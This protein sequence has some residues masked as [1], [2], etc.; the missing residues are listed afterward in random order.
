MC[1]A[2]GREAES[3]LSSEQKGEMPEEP[4]SA[5]SGDN[6]SGKVYLTPSPD[7]SCH[8][9]VSPSA[10]SWGQYCGRGLVNS[11]PRRVFTKEGQTGS[12]RRYGSHRGPS[13]GEMGAKAPLQTLASVV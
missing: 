3:C 5:C 6:G 2:R 1:Q 13:S 8:H 11:L 7:F 4:A 9:P 12:L 10:Q